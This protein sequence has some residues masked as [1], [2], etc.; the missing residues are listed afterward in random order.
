MGEFGRTPKVNSG[1]PGIPIPGRDHWG[2]AISVMMAG[3][4]LRGGVVVGQTNAR[5][6]HPID[7]PLQPHD[8]LATVYHVMGV[9]TSVSFPD[10][11]GRP[12]PIL[13]AGEPIREL[14]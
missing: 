7:R 8:I 11:A 9:D 1:Q 2:D 12:I 14:I 3:G 13:S 6:E 10:H 5:A 4:G